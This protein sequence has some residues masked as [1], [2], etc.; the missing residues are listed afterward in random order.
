VFPGV[1][2][3]KQSRAGIGHGARQRE[4]PP[5]APTHSAA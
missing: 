4:N 2:Q 5:T 1:G 3:C